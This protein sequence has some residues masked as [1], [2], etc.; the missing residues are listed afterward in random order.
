MDQ[1]KNQRAVLLAIHPEYA[2]SILDGTKMVEFR[3]QC[4]SRHVQCIYLYSTSPIK[5]IVGS[6]HVENIVSDSIQHLWAKYNG[7]GGISRERFFEYF[8]NS[9][10]GC[11]IC[12]VRP[13]RAKSP[14]PLQK[15]SME[16]KPPQS[17]KYLDK[18]QI[19]TL[20]RMLL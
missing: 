14:I 9:S 10:T 2:S 15:I 16:L 17:F 7:N 19:T 18:I 13:F 20:E 5:A 1:N 6:V 3:K 12:L 8:K 4:F 11:A